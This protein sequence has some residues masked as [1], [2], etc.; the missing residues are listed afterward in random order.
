MDR[1]GGVRSLPPGDDVAWKLLGSA[2][3]V[4]RQVG[5]CGMELDGM[6]QAACPPRAS[7]QCSPQNCFAFPCA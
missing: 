7:R 4:S 5:G 1:S 3:Q 2:V 6:S